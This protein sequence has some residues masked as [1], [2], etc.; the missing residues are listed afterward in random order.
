MKR[1]RWL[2]LAG[3]LVI[4]GVGVA[5]RSDPLPT[6]EST[7]IGTI[8][9][10][11][12]H[13]DFERAYAPKT[14]HFPEDHGPHPR[15]KAE[16]WYL[17]GNLFAV[18]TGRHFGYECTLFRF[19][20]ATHAKERP[21]PW[22]TTQVHMGHL[23]LTDSKQG[24]FH[25]FQRFSRVALDLA[26][27]VADPFRVWLGDWS[28]VGTGGTPEQPSMH[29]EA[30]QEGVA[31]ELSLVATKPVVLQGD[32]GLSRKSP[33]PGNA[34]HYYSLPRLATT[35]WVVAGGERFQVS[36]LSWFDR[37]W[38][39]SSLAENQEG[40]DWFAL[41]LGDGWDLMV[42]RMREKSA[43]SS[44]TSGGTLID[45]EGKVTI[46][47]DD[48]VVVA[49]SESWRSPTTGIP[50][51]S[52][53]QLRIPA[54]NLDVTITPWLAD[55]ELNRTMVRYWEGA[56]RIHGNH[57]LHPV[58]GNGYVELAGYRRKKKI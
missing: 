4:V 5:W 51:P 8:L 43:P 31:V 28:L 20:L 37:E 34:S 22:G 24:A 39:T 7:L 2:I 42:Y 50:Y 58:Q 56:V 19:A 57:G 26:G 47:A 35:G 6:D 21:S 49:S 3:V 12:D 23:A 52:Q 1:H 30:R 46:L 53:W 54:R 48:A 15:Y 17:T 44:F 36:G 41:Q 16:W 9:G 18:D 11:G 29:L 27:A 25:H 32:H 33:E 38:S 14:W 10:N 40:W 45:P 13:A 55:Q